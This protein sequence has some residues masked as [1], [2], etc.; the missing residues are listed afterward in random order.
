MS[1]TRYGII[2]TSTGQFLMASN[3][4]SYGTKAER[5]LSWDT[6]AEAKL[7]AATLN[8]FAPPAPRAAKKLP[9]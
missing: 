8:S 1:T 3:K 9:A 7:F 2:D 4:G 6:K 5:E